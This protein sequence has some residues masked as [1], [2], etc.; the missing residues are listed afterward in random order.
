MGFG[1]CVIGWVGGGR[2]QASRATQLP[3]GLRLYRGLG[4]LHMPERF[5]RPDPA[6]GYRAIVEFGFMSTTANREVAIQYTGVAR[7]R[8]FPTLLEIRPAAVD[9]GADIGD[10]SQYPGEREYLWNPCSLLEPDGPERLEAT[11]DGLVTIIPVRMNLNVRAMTTEELVGEKRRMHCAAFGYLVEEL[12][13]ELP[14]VAAE[15]GAEARLARDHSWKFQGTVQS[16]LDG[17]V[18][19]CEEVLTRH[20]ALA[21]ER[22]ANDEVFRGLVQEML[23]VKAMALSKLRIWLADETRV[24][25]AFDGEPLRQAHRA[26][27]AHLRRTLAPDGPERARGA[28]RLCQL[29]GLMREYVH[30]S[31]ELGESRLAAAAAEGGDASALALLVEAGAAVDE[32]GPNTGF[33]AASLAAQ[34]GHGHTIVALHGL[35]A[36][37]DLADLG[38]ASPLYY[39]ARAGHDGAVRELVAHGAV[40]DAAQV[41][42]CTPLWIASANGYA[43]VAEILLEARADAAW[44]GHK[45]GATP[46]F[47]AAQGGYAELVEL[48]HRH[49]ASVLAARKDGVSPICVAAQGGRLAVVRLLASLSA[50]VN[51]ASESG[52]TALMAARQEG[53]TE[54][55]QA[56]VELGALSGESTS[57]DMFGAARAGDAAAITAIHAAGTSVNA[58]D[59]DGSTPLHEAAR[60]GHVAI[61][62]LLVGLG[63]ELQ[64]EGQKDGC[65]PLWLA[66]AVGRGS[67]CEALLRLGACVNTPNVNGATPLYMAAQGGHAEAAAA[68]LRGGAAPDAAL[69]N[70]FTAALA[71]AQGGHTAVVRMLATAGADLRRADASGHWTPLEIARQ[72]GHAETAAALVELGA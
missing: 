4:G 47:M 43:A 33:T 23:E 50:D 51:Q 41:D 58:R 39:A 31:N 64:P 48:L 38:G 35:G 26:Y 21:A 20:S 16:L 63:A 49:G 53:H 46:L 72:A 55:A 29:L 19:Q 70:G 7:G 22:F 69:P 52:F 25:N 34:N 3:D 10:F 65:T 67:C 68:L 12:R 59:V 14:R 13:R 18:R 42:G 60:A 32:K 66:A 28:A 54:T 61:V 1:G 6:T 36:N 45:S 9:H 44:A 62:E 71:A 40:V 15:E 57:L 30:E 27:V 37:L 56:L 8:P 5:R 24:A 2:L 17:V 11:A